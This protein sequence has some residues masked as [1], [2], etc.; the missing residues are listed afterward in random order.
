MK[1]SRRPT[2]FRSLTL[3]KSTIFLWSSSVRSP[4]TE[5]PVL[6]RCPAGESEDVGQNCAS[7][8]AG[9][10][11][12]ENICEAE[13]KNRIESVRLREYEPCIPIRGVRR[14]L[15]HE[16]TICAMRPQHSRNVAPHQK[17]KTPRRLKGDAWYAAVGHHFLLFRAAIA[18]ANRIS[19]SARRSFRGRSKKLSLTYKPRP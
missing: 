8:Q 15:T 9:Q 11:R 2:P 4:S 1:L 6:L 16:E 19:N 18:W 12:K 14:P 10:S 13:A 5:S 3:R 7:W 17:I